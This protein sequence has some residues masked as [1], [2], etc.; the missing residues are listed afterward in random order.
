MVSVGS[1]QVLCCPVKLRPPVPHRVREMGRTLLGGGRQVEQARVRGCAPIDVALAAAG[2]AV[3]LGGQ[4]RAGARALAIRGVRPRGALGG[5][6]AGILR[7]RLLRCWRRVCCCLQ[8]CSMSLNPECLP[9][10]TRDTW[11]RW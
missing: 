10:V 1:E 9:L 8:A 5:V 4:P 2:G 3:R 6:I 7:G 11:P